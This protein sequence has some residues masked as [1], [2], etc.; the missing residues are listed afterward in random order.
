MPTFTYTAVRSDGSRHEGSLE[1][2]HRTEALLL[3]GKQKLRPIKLE[4]ASSSA[5]EA[6]ASVRTTTSSASASSG[7]GSQDKP[8]VTGAKFRF[9]GANLADFTE[10]L[11]DLLDAGMALDPALR[12]MEQRQDDS[13][14]KRAAAQVRQQI[15]EGT[16]LSVALRRTSPSFNDLYCNLVAAGE[17]SGALPRILR[18]QHTFL[19]MMEEIRSK[20]LGAL[21]YPCVIML[22]GFVLLFIVSTFLGPQLQ[23]MLAKMGREQPLPTRMLLAGSQFITR[24]WWLLGLIAFA[25]GSGFLSAI[26]SGRGRDLWHKWQLRLPLIGPILTAQFHAT[27]C[28][29]LS[30]L[31]S[32]GIPLLNAMQ[33]VVHATPNIHIRTSLNKA[34]LLVAEGAPLSRALA[35]SGSFPTALLDFIVVGEQTG[36]LALALEKAGA[37]Y[38][39]VLTRSIAFLT[40]LIQPTIVI[41]MA[42]LVGLVAYSIISGIFAAVSG[43]RP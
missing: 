16:S 14:I 18:R 34:T 23:T 6:A 13:P 3:L 29:T 1:A 42:L 12:V 37:R 10:E 41:A 43:L 15:R 30:T 2:K 35:R 25:L 38:D 24:W 39:K 31:V 26:R 33:L 7:S 9:S 11:G 19:V 4:S 5:P 32:S 17:A 21:I 28:H 36:N 8:S 40:A 27:L 22:C 20:A